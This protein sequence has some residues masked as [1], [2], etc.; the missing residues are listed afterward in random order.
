[1]ACQADAGQ[2]QQ[3]GCLALRLPA[4]NI[5]L[6]Y[7]DVKLVTCQSQSQL[8]TTSGCVCSLLGLPIDV[9]LSATS[10]ATRSF[11]RDQISGRNAVYSA[12]TA[13]TKED[14]LLLAV[15]KVVGS[16]LC[17]PV[18]TARQ[19]AAILNSQHPHC[20]VQASRDKLLAEGSMTCQQGTVSV[21]LR[22][23]VPVR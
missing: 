2:Y 17:K 23:H 4:I 3:I 15:A 12:R 9:L 1:M 7:A 21:L 6:S 16:S 18:C 10:V 11:H 13:G 5:N 8:V 22:L 14:L 19:L 20:D